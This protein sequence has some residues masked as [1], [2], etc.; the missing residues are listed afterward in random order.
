MKL[1]IR[2]QEGILIGSIKGDA[3]RKY[4]RIISEDT[5]FTFKTTRT[6]AGTSGQYPIYV[7]LENVTLETAEVNIIIWRGDYI[8]LIL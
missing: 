3:A 8:R 2:A 4:H 7:A 6:Y 1:E 5:R